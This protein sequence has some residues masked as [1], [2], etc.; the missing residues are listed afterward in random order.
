MTQITQ[1][2]FVVG[3]PRSGTTLLQS[4]LGA[5]PDIFAFPE[6]QFFRSLHSKRLL[7]RALRMGSLESYNRIQQLLKFV[8]RRDLAPGYTAMRSPNALAEKF[9]AILDEIARANGC[10]MWSEK[11]PGHLHHIE[12]ITDR[13]AEARFVHV[14]RSGMDT[15][16]SLRHAALKYPK[17]HWP[18]EYPDLRSCFEEWERAMQ[19]ST[20]YHDKPGHVLV[21]YESVVENPQAAAQTLCDALD[22]KY[23]ADILSNRAANAAAVTQDDEPWKSAVVQPVGP[24]HNKAL[25]VLTDDERAKV[26]RWVA[27]VRTANCSQ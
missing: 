12:Y 24:Q 25:E 16:A 11:S 21:R 27:D 15:I 20:M 4:M 17:T 3:C 18:R 13:V 7:L 6:T 8:D 26:A 2:I 10:S 19:V 5:H 14:I 1:R 23:T 22:I 9:I